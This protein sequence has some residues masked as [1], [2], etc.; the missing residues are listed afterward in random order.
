MRAGSEVMCGKWLVAVVKRNLPTKISMDL[1]M[2]LRKLTTVDEIRHAINIHR[3]DHRTGLPRGVPG[4]MLAMTEQPAE[5]EPTSTSLNSTT[6]NQN[7]D[8]I[9][10]NDNDRKNVYSMQ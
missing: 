10:N 3:H 9:N 7:V 2:E 1:S 8:S 6:Q 4:S 5:P